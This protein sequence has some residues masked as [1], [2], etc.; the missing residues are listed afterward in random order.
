MLLAT[1]RRALT[2]PLCTEPR[3][4]TPLDPRPFLGTA[5]REPLSGNL[6]PLI[7]DFCSIPLHICI[8]TSPHLALKSPNSVSCFILHH[9]MLS[10]SAHVLYNHLNISSANRFVNAVLDLNLPN[11]SLHRKGKGLT[12]TIC[13]PF[14][15]TFGESCYHRSYASIYNTLSVLSMS[16]NK[17]GPDPEGRSVKPIGAEVVS[18][19]SYATN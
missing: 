18:P 2:V 4:R 8:S 10:V 14:G 11:V 15:M 19:R 7:G 6:G 13:V 3:T 12:V 16:S 9:R 5:E 17:A 1:S